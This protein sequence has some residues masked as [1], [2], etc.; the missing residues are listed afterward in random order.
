MTLSGAWLD[1]WGIHC[2]S[3]VIFVSVKNGQILMFSDAL[4][5]T[6][7]ISDYLQ[8]KHLQIQIS[9]TAKN[10][11]PRSYWTSR[12]DYSPE[13][14]VKGAW[15]KD[16]GFVKG[17]RIALTNI[18]NGFILIETITPATRWHEILHKK[19]LERDAE[20]A[21]SKLRAHK[22]AHPSLYQETSEISRN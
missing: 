8:G 13:L 22:S 3:E 10:R 9:R 15:L 4:P 1:H 16:W 11:Q 6:S 20:L 2:D 19:K 12:R 18:R 5:A 7:D 21:L 17:S 14:I